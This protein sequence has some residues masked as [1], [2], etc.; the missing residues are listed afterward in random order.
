MEAYKETFTAFKLTPSE[1]EIV[2]NVFGTWDGALKLGIKDNKRFTRLS[3]QEVER[4]LPKAPLHEGVKPALSKLKEEGKVL[5]VISTS[6][7]QF[8]RQALQ[9]NDLENL[10]S[11]VVTT[12]DVT[13]DKPD[14][15]CVNQAL[16]KLAGQK[17]QAVIIGDSGKDV[18]AGQNAGVATV[19]FYP[20]ANQRFYASDTVVSW[21]ADYV[22]KDFSK[23]LNL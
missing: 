4:R 23:V 20:P 1:E 18:Q 3:L 21:R 11:A 9:H 10:F 14:P 5:A 12:E 17:E 22:I 19:V 15:E 13:R 16:N 7:D 2:K 8:V 6:K